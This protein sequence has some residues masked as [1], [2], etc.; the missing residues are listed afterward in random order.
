MEAPRT[1]LD[2]WLE[3][4]RE[5]PNSRLMN[6]S[7]GDGS[8]RPIS[9]AEAETRIRRIALG[10]Y[11]LGVESGDRVALLSENRPD[12][13]LVDLAILS[14]GAATVPI[15]TTQQTEQIGHILDQSGAKVL[16]VS[17]A[18]HGERIAPALT[19]ASSLRQVVTFD[20]KPAPAPPTVAAMTLAELEALGA[21][22][23][24]ERE[25]ALD[26]M[27]RAI[28][29]E[30]LATLIFTSGTTGEPKGVMLTHGNLVSNVLASDEVLRLS[31]ERDVILSFLPLSHILERMGLY[32]HLWRGL[33]IYYVSSIDEVA[34]AL[35]SVRPTVMTVVPRLM[36]KMYQKIVATGMGMPQP[37]RGIF[38]WSLRQAKKH[39]V[40]RPD[41]PL[42][43]IKLALAD[44]LVLS[45]WRDVFG[46]RIRA[47]VSGGAAFPEA[48]CHVYDAA[49][50]TVI[51]GYGLTETSPV[52]TVN[53]PETNRA[54]SVGKPLSGNTIQIAADGEVLARGPNVM[55]G[56]YKN[57]TATAEVLDADG[58][59]HTGDIGEI[60]ADGF[61]FITDRK[62]EL[63][64]TSGGKYVAPQPIESKLK[65]SRFVE[66]VVVIGDGRRFPSALIVPNFA[67]LAAH[68]AEHKLP[69]VT[70]RAALIALPEVT[71]LFQ[72]EI[73][74]VN[75]HLSHPEQIKKFALLDRELTVEQGEM[76][77]T[78]KVRRKIILDHFSGLIGRLYAS[79]EA[80]AVLNA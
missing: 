37:K 19:V 77:P 32:M 9:S 25:A 20:G 33:P 5:R 67:A 54:G 16:F 45:K 8:W 44:K 80:D 23:P 28:T 62:K 6:V 72:T 68:R 65:A 52:I 59:F 76:T 13:N 48:L 41:A 70:D 43:R 7:T 22:A 21:D 14:L 79:A 64:K 11:A 36:E 3:G 15:Y 60:D 34:A 12:W 71:A 69:E 17:T 55:T 61:L 38:R 75:A 74:E 53:R 2:L 63:L 49:G 31:P 78:L 47:I 56:Y 57:P 26:E 50:I 73:D 1:L 39:R 46:G 18:A 27:R 10:L 4:L 40:G 29:P 51:Q 24:A 35:K 58:W 66:Q 42:D 30:T